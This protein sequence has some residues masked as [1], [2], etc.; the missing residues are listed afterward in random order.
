MK[1]KHPAGQ[2]LPKEVSIYASVTSL[3][4]ELEGFAHGGVC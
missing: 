2:N 1:Y 3:V 4:Y